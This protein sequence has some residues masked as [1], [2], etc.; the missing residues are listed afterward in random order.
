MTLY[1]N[2]PSGDEES[3]GGISTLT[4]A[5]SR[6]LE[7]TLDGISR[8]DDDD[9][10][11]REGSAIRDGLR[12]HRKFAVDDVR[13]YVLFTVY[14]HDS[15]HAHDL[16]YTALLTPYSIYFASYV[17]RYM[18]SR[19]SN[20]VLQSSYYYQIISDLYSCALPLI[21]PW[22]IVLM[23]LDL[24]G[25][26]AVNLSPT[27]RDVIADAKGKPMQFDQCERTHEHFFGKEPLK[28]KKRATSLSVVFAL[29]ALPSA[30]SLPPIFGVELDLAMPRVRD[31]SAFHSRG[32]V[33]GELILCCVMRG[34]FRRLARHQK[35]ERLVKRWPLLQMK[36]VRRRTEER[37]DGDGDAEEEREDTMDCLQLFVMNEDMSEMTAIDLAHEC[38][39]MTRV[40]GCGWPMK[41][42]FILNVY[43]RMDV[44]MFR[45]KHV[46]RYYAHRMCVDNVS[47]GYYESQHALNEFTYL[48]FVPNIRLL[49]T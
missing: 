5:C 24:I 43:S 12:L 16:S 17:Q 46:R 25:I 22:D 20:G 15:M 31:E 26:D 23:I 41:T 39:Q 49:P 18:R 30:S 40:P 14:P 1:H 11:R 47:Y 19:L 27:G 28:K 9:W 42:V 35:D 38:A 2:V 8:L 37:D 34:F 48:E 33:Y 4:L 45:A 3:S 6:P 21:L 29:T 32:A 10:M 44:L 36:Y 13:H 7:R